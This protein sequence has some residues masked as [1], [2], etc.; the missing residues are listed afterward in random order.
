MLCKQSHGLRHVLYTILT[1]ISYLGFDARDGDGSRY[2]EGREKGGAVG[3]LRSP[4]FLFTQA[5]D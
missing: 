3:Y 5:L 1:T 2:R 4:A